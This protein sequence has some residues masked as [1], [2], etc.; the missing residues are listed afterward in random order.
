MNASSITFNIEYAL[1][2]PHEAISMLQD[3][4]G[5]WRPSIDRTKCVRCGKCEKS[6]PIRTPAVQSDEAKKYYAVYA[7]DPLT[8]RMGSSGNAFGLCA[9]TV[10]ATG[11]EVFGA[12]LD[13]ACRHLRIQSAADVGLARTFSDAAKV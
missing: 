5:F 11:G 6:C 12:A 7:Q 13:A 1:D 3:E 8:H 4:A 10:L 9:R 2:T